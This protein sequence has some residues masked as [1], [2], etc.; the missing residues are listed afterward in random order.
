MRYFLVIIS[1][2]LVAVAGCSMSGGTG[3]DDT[4]LSVVREKV[5]CKLEPFNPAC[6]AGAGGE[7]IIPEDEDDGDGEIVNTPSGFSVTGGN[8][9]ITVEKGAPIQI[10]LGIV[11]GTGKGPFLWS[12]DGLWAGATITWS[13]AGYRQAA[14][15]WTPTE[16]KKVTFTVMVS[17]QGQPSLAPRTVKV[18]VLV[19]EP[20]EISAYYQGGLIDGYSI[21]KEKTGERSY[22]AKDP[23]DL[24]KYGSDSVW[25]RLTVG[26][27]T[28]GGGY[29]FKTASSRFEIMPTGCNG[30]MCE[31]VAIP[32]YY[33]QDLTNVSFTVTSKATGYSSTLSIPKVLLVPEGYAPEDNPDACKNG[34][35]DDGDGIIDCKDTDCQ[36]IYPCREK[37]NSNALCTDGFDN[38]GDGKKDCDD[39]DCNSINS[40]Y[41]TACRNW[42]IDPESKQVSSASVE[43]DIDCSYTSTTVGDVEITFWA[44]AYTTTATHFDIFKCGINTYVVTGLF[45]GVGGSSEYLRNIEIALSPNSGN[46][47]QVKSVKITYRQKGDIGSFTEPRYAYWNPCISQ[48][49]R[50]DWAKSANTLDLSLNDTAFCLAQEYTDTKNALSDDYRFYMSGTSYSNVLNYNSADDFGSKSEFSDILALELG[51]YYGNPWNVHGYLKCNPFNTAP[52]AE[53]REALYESGKISPFEKMAGRYAAVTTDKEGGWNFDWYE[54]FIFQPGNSWSYVNGKNIIK[55]NAIHIVYDENTSNEPVK[56]AQDSSKCSI[57]S[58]ADFWSTKPVDKFKKMG[59]DKILPIDMS[60]NCTS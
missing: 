10:P 19:K 50:S 9:T 40:I 1:V 32:K 33:S 15:S 37:E 18:G 5:D 23:V 52:C 57:I 46:S 29:E 44:R 27:L 16:Y 7:E 58:N 26:N 30:T 3:G 14:I 53:Q 28:K 31:A 54:A 2:A 17:D 6:A 12:F 43:L 39:P 47:A 60:L 22:R 21:Q 42:F 38:D 20:V 41:V 24:R 25:L 56:K 55:G 59:R 51:E 11:E 34:K 8:K 48:Q 13:G 49:I 35:D 45:E 36:W 4:D